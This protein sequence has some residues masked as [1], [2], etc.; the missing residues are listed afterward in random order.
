[1]ISF[2]T[3]NLA[4]HI[5]SSA[6]TQFPGADVEKVF[7]LFRDD[8]KKIAKTLHSIRSKSD[9]VFY[10]VVSPTHAGMIRQHCQQKGIGCMDLIGP[11]RDFFEQNLGVSPLD[12]ADELFKIDDD[13]FKRIDAMEFTLQ[14]D[15]SRR[16]DSIDQ[17]EIVLLGISRVS[18]SPTSTFLGSLGYRTANVSVVPAFGLPPE[19]NQCK[20][21][22][23]ALTMQ[24]HVLRQVRQRRFEINGFASKLAE[25]G[26]SN[27]N[28]VN[29]RDVTREVMDADSLYR[30][31]RF[32]IVDVTGMTIEESAFQ[33]LVALRLVPQA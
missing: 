1:M 31:N 15:D 6:L 29:P 8:E 9:L 16:L 13:Y 5:V 2:F 20:G 4:N 11:I 19:L 18:K 28:Y 17:A 30:K 25:K 23:V 10:A 33:V 7:H 22:V 27:L 12:E 32:P 14:H 3:G 26:D 21:R 24:P